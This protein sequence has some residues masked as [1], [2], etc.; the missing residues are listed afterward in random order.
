MK[1]Q[2]LLPTVYMHILYNLLSKVF[3]SA[4]KSPLELALI[5][6]N[7]YG[8]QLLRKHI[9]TPFRMHPLIE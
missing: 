1:L 6:S 3:A 7:C 8:T 2:F 4:A 5:L 9:K